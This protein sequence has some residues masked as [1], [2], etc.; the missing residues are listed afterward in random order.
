MEFSR[1]S[2]HAPKAAH[3]IEADWNK[4]RSQIRS[5]TKQLPADEAK[6]LG[7]VL[8]KSKAKRFD[9]K[10]RQRRLRFKWESLPP[11]VQN[12][13][14]RFA[15][16]TPEII[17]A[18]VVDPCRP[19][20]REW[21][22]YSLSG[23]VLR[24]NKT[25]YEQ[26][27][28]ILLGENTF[29]FNYQFHY[30]L[31]L[32][33]KAPRQRGALIRKIVTGP[34]LQPRMAKDLKKLTHL[35]EITILSTSSLALQDEGLEESICVEKY[36]EVNPALMGKVEESSEPTVHFVHQFRPSVSITLTQPFLKAH[37]DSSRALTK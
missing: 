35:E 11:E 14:F 36:E 16:T 21:Q 2:T 23:Q 28:P 18:R 1:A 20:R 6:E 8:D 22:R 34:Q 26:T 19:G 33:S 29:L 12:M 4:T 3:T 31:G 10:S 32:G 30:I 7:D 15:M 24:L 27:L 9:R 17:K 37:T 13:I 25:I 5:L